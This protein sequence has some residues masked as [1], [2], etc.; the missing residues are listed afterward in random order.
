MT[1]APARLR[2][3]GL[4]KKVGGSYRYQLTREGRQLITD[5]LSARQADAEK[6]LA[7]AA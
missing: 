6:L 7:L 5:L 1:G 2:A 3:H 4:I